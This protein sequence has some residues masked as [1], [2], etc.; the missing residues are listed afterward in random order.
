MAVTLRDIAKALNLSHATVSF[1]LND[2]RDVAIPESTRQRVM[3]TARAMGYRPNRA[4]R[5]LVSGR[6]NMIG[7]W[8]A[9]PE[10]PYY[11]QML[12]HLASILRSQG[13]ETLLSVASI[14]DLGQRVM[15]WPVDGVIAVDTGPFVRPG[16]ALPDTPFVGVGAYCDD[17]GDHVRIDLGSGA[18]E[19]VRHLL[20]V[21]CRRIAYIAT[22][23]NTDDVRSQTYARMMEAEGRVPMFLPVGHLS[24]DHMRKVLEEQS[25]ID[26]L[27]CA[28]DETA[29]Y[30]LAAAHDVGRKVPEDLAVVGFDGIPVGALLPV[31]LTSVVQPIEEAATLAV[32]T[33][34]ER[35]KNPQAPQASKRLRSNLLIRESS[36]RG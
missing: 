20:S 16:E 6:T 5:A 36:R 24:R 2:R 10:H 3:E 18:E 15:D 4:A 1:V 23:L 21:G 11:A 28:N 9:S 22:R 19:A 8:Q 35:I 12:H 34:L 26:G 7:L 32:Q 25:H 31:A 13:Y 27:L 14:S 30:V 33:L 17:R 29:L